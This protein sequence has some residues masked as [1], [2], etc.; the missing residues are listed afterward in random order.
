MQE[1]SAYA[2]LG[3]RDRRERPPRR[4]GLEGAQRTEPG[5]AGNAVR[6][7]AGWSFTA[8]S[9]ECGAVQKNKQENFEN[10]AQGIA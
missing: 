5:M 3:G 7:T 6:G 10:K 8:E 1:P 2:R 4:R 9:G